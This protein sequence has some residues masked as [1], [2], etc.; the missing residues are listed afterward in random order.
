MGVLLVERPK[1]SH[2]PAMSNVLS[3]ASIPRLKEWR[4]HASIRK[5]WRFPLVEA[6]CF[7]LQATRTSTEHRIAAW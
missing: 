6:A 2:V 4:P 3:S 7:T 1:S 5:T